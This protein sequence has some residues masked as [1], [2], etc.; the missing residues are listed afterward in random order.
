MLCFIIK[1]NLEIEKANKIITEDFMWLPQ[2]ETQSREKSWNETDHTST[3]DGV[4]GIHYYGIQ[5]SSTNKIQ[6]NQNSKIIHIYTGRD[7]VMFSEIQNLDRVSVNSQYWLHEKKTMIKFWEHILF[8][9]CCSADENQSAWKAKR[10]Q[11]TNAV[12][13]WEKT[14]NNAIKWVITCSCRRRKEDINEHQQVNVSYLI[15]V[16]YY[17][18]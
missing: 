9:E 15:R 1:G 16:N 5:M 12:K 18:L 8:V 7:R 13:S 3:V 2:L 11:D 10:R 6:Y 17:E 4:I 14:T